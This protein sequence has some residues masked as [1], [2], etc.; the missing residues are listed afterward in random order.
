MPPAKTFDSRGF[1][2]RRRRLKII[3]LVLILAG[4]FTI[5]DM[6]STIPIPLTGMRAIFAGVVLLIFG[7]LAVYHGYKL[8]LAEAIELIH[9]NGRGIT[10]SELVHQMRVD[11]ATATRIIDALI[12]KGF[13]RTSAERH[14]AEEV[15]DPVQ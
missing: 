14:E 4:V 15:Y 3:G 10:A 7:F 1:H 5:L 6:V 11:R 2:R 12:R 13:L 9:G 8:P